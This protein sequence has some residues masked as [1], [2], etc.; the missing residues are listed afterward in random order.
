MKLS[1][2]LLGLALLSASLV[3]SHKNHKDDHYN[4]V[5]YTAVPGYFLQD[6]PDTDPATFDYVRCSFPDEVDCGDM[7]T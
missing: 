4:Y 5:R 1:N 6:E 2:T 3:H 7:M